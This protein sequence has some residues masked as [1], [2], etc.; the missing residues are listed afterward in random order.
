M[1]HT[2]TTFRFYLLVAGVWDEDTPFTILPCF[3]VEFGTPGDKFLVMTYNF[4]MEVAVVKVIRGIHSLVTFLDL[5]AHMK[6][7]YWFSRVTWRTIANL[8]SD[9]TSLAQLGMV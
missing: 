1:M 3:T 8:H 7:K 9:H 4:N 2:R 5:V 6:V